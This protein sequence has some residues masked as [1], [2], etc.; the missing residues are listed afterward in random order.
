LTAANAGLREDAIN[1]LQAFINACEAQRD[2]AL[3]T[4]Q[5]DMLIEMA[6]LIIASL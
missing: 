4:E 1:K 5:A 2:K 3:T 6:D